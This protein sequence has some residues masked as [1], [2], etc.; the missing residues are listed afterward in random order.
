MNMGK[1]KQWLMNM[2]ED[3]AEMSK[4]IF[5]FKHGAVPQDIWDRVNDPNYDDGFDFDESESEC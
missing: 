2:E 1:V 4:L 3:A 5:C